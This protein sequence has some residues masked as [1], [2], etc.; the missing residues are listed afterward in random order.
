MFVVSPPPSTPPLPPLPKQPRLVYLLLV[1]YSVLLSVLP[2]ATSCL[3]LAGRCILYC[4]QSYPQPRPA[5]L[6]LVVCIVVSPTHSHVWLTSCS[7][8]YSVLFRPPSPPLPKQ[9]RRAYLLLVVYSV[10]LSAPPPLSPLPPLPKHPRPRRCILYC[11]V[12][13]LTH[14]HVWLTSCS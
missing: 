13:V 6:L 7:S 8:V 1:V 12:S 14:S 2:T 9:P 10:L 5:Y 4:C 3:P 11:S